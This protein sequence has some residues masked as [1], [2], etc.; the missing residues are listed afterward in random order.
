MYPKRTKWIHVSKT[1]DLDTYPKIDECIERNGMYPKLGDMYPCF[2]E[3]S[4]HSQL[5]RARPKHSRMFRGRLAAVHKTGR[6]DPGHGNPRGACGMN[7]PLISACTLLAATMSVSSRGMP[8]LLA[9]YAI[10]KCS[11]P[12]NACRRPHW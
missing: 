9:S 7:H 1:D 8:T 10:D 4:K 11:T 6:P 2:G 3:C 5:L 12:P